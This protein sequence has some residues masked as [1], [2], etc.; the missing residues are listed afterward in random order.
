[1]LAEDAKA[2]RAEFMEKKNQVQS[3]MGEHIAVSKPEDKPEPYSHEIF[4][5]TA[6]EWLI[7]TNHV[8][9]LGFICISQS[10][11]LSF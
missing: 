10:L 11:T 5:R 7:Q 4:K 8:I 6:I 2:R 3:T 9:I 1:M